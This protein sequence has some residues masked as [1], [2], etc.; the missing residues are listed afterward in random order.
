MASKKIKRCQGSRASG[1]VPHIL[2]VR[3]M[4]QPLGKTF[5]QFLKNLNTDLSK[6]PAISL[7][8]PYPENRKWYRHTK[9]YTWTSRRQYSQQQKTAKMWTQ[10]KYPPPDGWINT[11]W[12]L[13]EMEFYSAIKRNG[14]LIQDRKWMNLANVLNESSKTE[15]VTHTIGFYLPEMSR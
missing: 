5:S 10:P 7:L 2:L 15:T 11:T 9:T 14:V 12:Y 3:N 1:T 13:H 8:G 4:A 6:D